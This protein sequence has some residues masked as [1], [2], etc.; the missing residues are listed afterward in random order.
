MY[1]LR[2]TSP[3]TESEPKPSHNKYFRP[4]HLGL[5]RPPPTPPLIA[6]SR[7]PSRSRSLSTPLTIATLGASHSH[8][9]VQSQTPPLTPARCLGQ[10]RRSPWPLPN[11]WSRRILRSHSPSIASTIGPIVGAAPHGFCFTPS[12]VLGRSPG[13]EREERY[14]IF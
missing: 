3:V 10:N 1:F 5:T 7:R 9:S 14:E 4:S 2:E 12:T 13:N 6:R 8:H 11:A